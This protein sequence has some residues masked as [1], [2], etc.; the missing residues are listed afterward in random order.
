MQ[1]AL[2][3]LLLCQSHTV[4]V[5][6][7][8]FEQLLHRVERLPD[9][10]PELALITTLAALSAESDR[11]PA[12]LLIAI[13]WGES[14]LEPTTKTGRACGPMQTIAVKPGDC[15]RWATPL[16]GYQAGVDELTEWSNDKR[17]RGDLELV[18]LAYACGSS[19]FNGTCKKTSWPGWVL[20]RARRL[21][22]K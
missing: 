1:A 11:F 18:L 8:H 22:M 3:V 4:S 6:K 12:E 15:E 19:A 5:E 2:I 10:R 7:S 9:T 20:K 13:A 21:G 16:Y 14:R 17:T